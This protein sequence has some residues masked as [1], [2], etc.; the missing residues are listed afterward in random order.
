MLEIRGQ[1]IV[2]R[3]WRV[4]QRYVY[5]VGEVGDGQ[6]GAHPRLLQDASLG[7]EGLGGVVVA[8]PREVGGGAKEEGPQH[9][10]ELE[11]L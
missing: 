9:L 2:F 10:P 7:G 3:I 8:S 5:H 4:P 11:I 6:V 1:N